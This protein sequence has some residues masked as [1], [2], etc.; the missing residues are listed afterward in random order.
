[1]LY[2]RHLTPL[3]RKALQDC[4]VVMITGARQTGK[5][6]LVQEIIKTVRQSRYHT[7]DDLTM[8]NA[9]QTDPQGFLSGFDGLQ[10]IDEV[11][12][13]PELLPAIKMMVDRRRRPGRFLLT[14]SANVLT[15]PRVSESLAGRMEVFTLWPL[16][17]GELLGR[18]ESF[19]DRLFQKKMNLKEDS[20]PSLNIWQHVTR[21][22]YPE[23]VR[24]KTLARRTAWFRSYVNTML[25]RDV[26]ELSAINGLTQMPL[27]LKLLATRIG[28]LLNWAELARAMQMP[29]TSIKRYFS[30][31]ELTYLVQR[32]LPWH[33]NLGKRL[34]KTPKLYFADTGLASHLMGFDLGSTTL[35]SERTGFLLEN[36]VVAELQKQIAW[37][38][39]QPG[40]YHFR[41]QTGQEVDAILEDRQGRCVCL[42]IKASA[43]VRKENFSNLVWL[44]GHLGNRFVRGVLLYTGP[45][46]VSFGPN[47]LACPIDALWM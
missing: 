5:T 6:T 7:L 4:P 14:G 23:V 47:L 46:C 25:Q 17:Q 11:Q 26:R 28:S 34:I 3:V 42:E 29:Q 22:G 31:L 10:A 2:L 36:F 1:M 9:A 44:A 32:V 21:G 41:S 45:E 39:T 15:L 37:S 19:V 24:R 35:V 33:G 18:K 13:V 12:I 38:R 20:S 8:R 27:L 43:T 16:S 30:L 40:L